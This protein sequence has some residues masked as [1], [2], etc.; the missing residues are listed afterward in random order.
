MVFLVLVDFLVAVEGV[1]AV[2]DFLPALGNL[3]LK[4]LIGAN[5]RATHAAKK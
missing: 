3:N 4:G 5:P 1:L 2:A